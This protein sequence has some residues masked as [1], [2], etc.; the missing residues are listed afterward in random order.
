MITFEKNW[1]QMNDLDVRS[2]PFDIWQAM[3][4]NVSLPVR[5]MQQPLASPAMGH[6]GTCPPPSTYNIVIFQCSLTYAKSN[7]DY[8]STVAS[9]KNSATSACAPPGTKSWRLHW[10]QQRVC[11]AQFPK[12]YHSHIVHDCLPVTQRRLSAFN[13]S[14]KLMSCCMKTVTNVHRNRR[15]ILILLNIIFFYALF[16]A[17]IC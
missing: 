14:V 10:Q 2:M 8:M 12:R 15:L 11:S 5:G 16:L 6:W 1:Q 7:S 3:V 4:G 9:C 17:T 13:T